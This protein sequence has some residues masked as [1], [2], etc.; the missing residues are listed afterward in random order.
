MSDFP[1]LSTGAVMQYPSDRSHQYS[2]R[3]LK[4]VDGGEQRYREQSAAAKRWIVRL[5][6]LTDGEATDV[7]QFCLGCQGRF[8][9]FSFTDPW[10]NTEHADCSLENDVI[11]IE[12][13]GESR[14]K[15]A[16]IVRKNGF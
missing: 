2:T 16:L 5:D 6:A 4:F 10:D 8:G 12:Q 9:S 14:T 7:E 15:I 13:A 3:V 1:R 11:V